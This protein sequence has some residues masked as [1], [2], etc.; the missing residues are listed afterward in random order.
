MN[1]HTNGTAS[2]NQTSP[3][4]VATPHHVMVATIRYGAEVY[5]LLRG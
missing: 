5:P 3:L 1:G 4:Q 2:V